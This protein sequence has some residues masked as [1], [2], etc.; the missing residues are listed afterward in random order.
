MKLAVLYFVVGVEKW[1][2]GLATNN[3]FCDWSDTQYNVYGY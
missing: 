1:G 2:S 3:V